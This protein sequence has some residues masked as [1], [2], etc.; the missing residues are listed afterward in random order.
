MK[1]RVVGL[2]C[3]CAVALTTPIVSP[4]LPLAAI[5]PYD[6]QARNPRFDVR[7]QTGIH[8][9]IDGREFDGIRFVAN[10]EIS[11]PI[12]EGQ[13]SFSAILVYADVHTAQ[14]VGEF[15]SNRLSVRI[16]LD[17][18]LAFE[19]AMDEASPP[20]GF[21][22]PVEGAR[23]ITIT[24]AEDYNWETFVLLNAEFSAQGH[25]AESGFLPAAGTGYV[26]FSP[27]ARQTLF[28]VFRPG[29]S[30]RLAAYFSGSASLAQVIVRVT[31][32]Q[33]KKTVPDATLPVVLHKMRT[34]MSE[35][36]VNWRVPAWR[37]PAMLDVEE[38]VSGTTVFHRKVR[39]A[40]APQLDLDA[41]PDSMFALHTSSP[42]FL[43]LQDEFAS[44]WGA[45][46]DRVLVRWEL[47]EP[48]PG[49]Y[50][51]SRSDAIVDS[52]RSQHIKVLGVLGE[53]WPSWV[54]SPGPSYID[55]WR[56]FVKA[57]ARHYKDQIEYWDVF[58]EIDVKYEQFRKTDPDF[59][60]EI[61][62]S[63]METLRREDSK[64]K[65][66]CC[67][68][69]MTAWLPYYQRLFN[70]QLL[71]LMD[72]VSLHPY[73]L[74]APEEKDGAF[75]YRD[76]LDALRQLIQSAGAVRPIWSTEA[77]W[78]LGARGAPY[79]T[80][81]DLDEHTQA[82]YIVRVNLISW[83]DSVPYFLHSP[84]YHSTRKELHLDSLAAYA[85][86]ASVFS[87]AATPRVLLNGPDV[88]GCTGRTAN[89]VVGALWTV[90]NTATVSL[91]GV[92]GVSFADL[93]GNSISAIA[94]SLTIT[95][96][97]TYF[98]APRGSVPKI[99]I[100]RSP[101]P[102]QWKSLAPLS[103]WAR[104]KGSI[105]RKTDGGLEITSEPGKYTYQL[106]SP[107]IDVGTGSCYVARISL[108]PEDGGAMLFAVDKATEKRVGEP[109]YMAFV[110][111]GRQ[112]ESYV[113]FHTGSTRSIHLIIANANL[114][115]AVSRF[116]VLDQAEISQCR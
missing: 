93:Y 39:I 109:V 92:S 70:A 2:V 96:A 19:T 36:Q 13:G 99:S 33:T 78:I 30:V 58:N 4:A 6:M 98:V 86:M 64:L 56:N 102:L 5:P 87:N 91:Q 45:K 54:G 79:V 38:R 80:A 73:E 83:T 34:S 47:V 52:V 51:F 25:P 108:N 75:N 63:G 48:T 14:P 49:H 114:V 27:L 35:G 88:F 16:F 105:F 17:D 53:S 20:Q 110:P 29:E 90:S 100:L 23:R 42:G 28:H 37:G 112:H 60:L 82:E 65:S 76:R 24:S 95:P 22:L 101:P 32:E 107:A 46:W 69:G 67:S 15:P 9:N 10:S 85:Q 41:I 8:L 94:S 97:V 68:P 89:D 21:A 57:T 104:T 66:V 12:P 43:E 55:A 61:L 103:N 81:P 77:N 71:P 113:R 26:D 40:I 106:R 84:F 1:F 50:D 111:D 44:L 11:Y 59:D 62:R 31:P 18:K 74:D 116:Q 72:V 7:P 115:P 3:F